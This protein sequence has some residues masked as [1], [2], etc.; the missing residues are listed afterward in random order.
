MAKPT[1]QVSKPLFHATTVTTILG[2][3]GCGKTFLSR[4]IQE[5]YPR[6]IVIDVTGEYSDGVECHTFEEFCTALEN[7]LNQSNFRIIFHSDMD[8]GV[9]EKLV[10]ENIIR[11]TMK[12]SSAHEAKFN[13]LLLVLEEVQHYSNSHSLPHYMRQCYLIGRHHGVALLA[14]S[15]RPAEVHKTIISQSHNIFAGKCFENNDI[16]YLSGIFGENIDQL[17]VIPE[18]EFL[19]KTDSSIKK[20]KNNLEISVNT[21]DNV[22][23]G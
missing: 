1:A 13:N 12:R 10:I 19:L 3:R 4:K 21:P 15:Q 17:T 18:R 23:S 2:M 14:T 6:V 22:N 5:L 16:K 8:A 7:S 11:L 9:D 20:V